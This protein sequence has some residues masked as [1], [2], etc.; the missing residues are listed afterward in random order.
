MHSF[1]EEINSFSDFTNLIPATP[2]NSNK[3]SQIR[4]ISIM[5]FMLVVWLF[6]A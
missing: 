3:D 6:H 1:S 4:S 2:V 5:H